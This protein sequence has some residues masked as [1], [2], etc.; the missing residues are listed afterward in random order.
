MNKNKDQNPEKQTRIRHQPF[1]INYVIPPLIG[2]IGIAWMLLVSSFLNNNNIQEIGFTAYQQINLVLTMQILVFPVSFILLGVLYL[3]NRKNF[4]K[5]FR[6]GNINA[7]SKPLKILGIKET[8]SWK[9]IGFTI[10]CILAAG[11]TIFMTIAVINMKGV[12]NSR[13]LALFPLALIFS[14]TN[15]WSE[16]IFTRFTVVAGLDKKVKPVYKYWISAAIFGIPHYFGTPGG[17]IGV[18]MAGF[19]GWLLAKSVH[20]TKGMF[21]AWFIHFIQDIIIFT[22][23]LMIIAASA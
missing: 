5:Y 15:A 3:Y 19:M 16:E 6:I 7:Y 11:T 22:A 20:E 21:W 13:V 23:N 14:T 4:L 2:L 8:D 9:K 10:A 17:F 18:V 12:F 1:K